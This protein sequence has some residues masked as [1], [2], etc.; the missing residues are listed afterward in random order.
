MSKE[1]K[2]VTVSAL[3]T[4][5]QEKSV[6]LEISQVAAIVAGEGSNA[7]KKERARFH[8]DNLRK[9]I[10]A[11]IKAGVESEAEKAG[12]SVAEFWLTNR[13]FGDG[14]AVSL[15]EQKDGGLVIE[16]ATKPVKYSDVVDV[17]K[18]EDL[19]YA[20]AVFLADARASA[21]GFGG[22]ARYDD[23][24]APSRSEKLGAMEALVRGLFGDVGVS[25][26]KKDFEMLKGTG[27][28]SLTLEGKTGAV[29]GRVR[30]PKYDAAAN[31][32][33]A[34]WEQQ[35]IALV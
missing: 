19:D 11:G 7:D 31:A 21:N 6:F 30:A 13:V 24:T 27:F 10:H 16:Y 2:K 29:Q 25:F 9:H 15:K 1:I 17:E 8:M 3:Y 12:V 20:E 4:A 5:E 34:R 14:N 32:V 26:Y 23:V 33:K 22:V 35:K 28:F 18:S